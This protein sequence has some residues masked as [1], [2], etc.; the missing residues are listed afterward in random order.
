MATYEVT[1]P[2]GRVYEVTAPEGANQEQVLEYAKTQFSQQQT[3]SSDPSKVSVPFSKMTREQQV[4]YYKDTEKRFKEGGWGSGLPKLADDIGGKITDLTGSP[5]A[6]FA[7]NV[8][9]QAIP[10]FA[11]SFSSGQPLMSLAKKPAEWLMGNALKPTMNQ[12][13][14]GKAARA[15]DTLLQEGVSPTKGGVETLKSRI[16]DL[17]DEITQALEA[18]TATVD[19]KVV[20]G[21]LQDAVNKFEK[22]VTPGADVKAIQSAWDE[23]L[24]HPLLGDKIPVQMAQELKKGTYKTLGEKA[25]GEQK[26]ASAE[27]QKTLA[28]GLKEEISQA[29]PGVAQANKRE[30]DLINAL[31][32]SEQS[33][34]RDANK[35]PIGLGALL[36][37]PWMLPVW[38]W[39]RSAGAKG[40]TARALFQGGRPE[41]FSPIGEAAGEGILYRKSRSE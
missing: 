28:R 16:T 7:A 15:I 37:Q 34:A 1:S 36:S 25:Y 22:Q 12:W 4:Q 20:A 8:A 21:Y 41:V 27:A 17:N 24:A 9:T 5:A 39:D 30:S 23:F 26:G 13:R 2:D 32:L 40:L 31:K 14:Q 6:G 19:K 35:N 38:M 3:K 11:S 33:A 29:V 10:A 18:S